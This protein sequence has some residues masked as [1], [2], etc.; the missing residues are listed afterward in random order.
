MEQ[1]EFFR[2][3]PFL[4]GV[5]FAAFGIAIWSWFLYAPPFRWFAELQLSSTGRYYTF[6]T[7]VLVCLAF[8]LPW[9]VIANVLIKVGVLRPKDEASES[10]FDWTVTHE[11]LA[12]VTLLSVLGLITGFSVATYAARLNR[13]DTLHVDQI[14]S[15]TR[16]SGGNV[17]LTGHPAWQFAMEVEDRYVSHYYVPFVSKNWQPSQPFHA[18]VV[19]GE[20]NLPTH[21]G[22]SIGDEMTVTAPLTFNGLPADVRY[23]WRQDGLIGASHVVTLEPNLKTWVFSNGQFILLIG[24]PVTLLACLGY[25]YLLW[26]RERPQS[27]NQPLASGPNDWLGTPMD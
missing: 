5:S 23:W 9:A 1:P 3:T 7:I 6:I 4:T 24:S 10:F 13:T 26:R 12:A 15:G 25:W 18:V 8:M 19:Y 17:Q 14:E 21:D 22:N 11:N 27:M 16:P 20:R 2:R